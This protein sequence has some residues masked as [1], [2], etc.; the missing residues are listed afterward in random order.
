MSQQEPKAGLIPYTIDADG[1][2]KL[3]FQVSSNP[4]FGGA[5]PMISKGCIEEGE[6]PVVAALREAMEE[7]GLRTS[8]IKNI[9]DIWLGWQGHVVLTS[10]SY[11]LAI[12]ACEVESLS[13]KDFDKPSYETKYTVPMTPES[14]AEKG[15]V[16]HR[17]IVELIVQ[18]IKERHH[19]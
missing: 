7:L 4:K 1:N 2:V 13:R 9:N 3:L 11:D 19:V 14:F 16:D 15:R 10:S 5:K 6:A 17:H 12:Y 18:Q 8:N